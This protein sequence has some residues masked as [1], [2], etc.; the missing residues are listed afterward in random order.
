[1]TSGLELRLGIWTEDLLFLVFLIL[2]LEIENGI[3]GFCKWLSMLIVDSSFPFHFPDG[4][5]SLKFRCS[6][7]K[8][9]FFDRELNLHESIKIKRASVSVILSFRIL[10]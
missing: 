8:E 7:F 6:S 1:M 3:L 10:L 5:P 9:H 4:L 2:K